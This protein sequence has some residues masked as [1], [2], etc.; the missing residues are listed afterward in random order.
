MMHHLIEG[1]IGL[2]Q[3]VDYYYLLLTQK[4]T[5]CSD[6]N[7]Q[8]KKYGLLKF[9]AGVMWI[10]GECLGLDAE[11]LLVKPNERIGRVILK[12]IMDGGSWGRYHQEHKF[13]SRR[14]NY[15][16]TLM[17]NDIHLVRDFPLEVICQ[18]IMLV[19]HQWWK[20]KTR[21]ILA[22]KKRSS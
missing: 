4:D 13:K 9:A 2:R 1:G 12:Q 8:F 7:E 22:Y 20:L 16:V 17:K 11:H 6:W 10:E 14:I 3:I 21:I 19:W 15:V 18:P 5:E